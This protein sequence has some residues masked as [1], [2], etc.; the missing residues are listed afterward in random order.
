MEGRLVGLLLS[1]FT[2]VDGT[3]QGR[4]FRLNYLD[5]LLQAFRGRLT[6]VG[7]R[8][9]G[10]I[11]NEPEAKI[12]HEMAR[13]CVDCTNARRV[14]SSRGSVLVLCDLVAQRS[15]IRQVS[16]FTGVGVRRPPHSNL[17]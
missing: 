11:K 10:R 5:A 6:G 13:L 15:A 1:T 2:G 4:V 16:A 3:N 8:C 9:A 14:E 12:S 7:P 17:T